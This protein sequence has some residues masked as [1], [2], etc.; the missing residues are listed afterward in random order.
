MLRCLAATRSEP[1]VTNFTRLPTWADKEHVHAVVET[2]RGSRCKLEFDPKLKVFTLS[3]PLLAGLTYPYDWG[4][5]PSTKAED[6]DPLDVLIIHDAAT[7]PGLVLRCKPIGVL[8]I[9]QTSKGKSERNDRVFA[10]PDR[11]PFEGDLQDIRHLPVRA[12]NELEKFFEATDAL[13]DKKITFLG[14][15]GPSEAI[16]TIRK[17]SR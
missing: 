6:G 8:R 12:V 14:W 1:D 9:L 11:A 10:L 4:F 5:V 13:E 3:K 17:H 15:K 7:Y 2:P 16:N